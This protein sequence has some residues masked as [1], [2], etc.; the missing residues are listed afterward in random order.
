VLIEAAGSGLLES[1]HDL[2][3]GGL[4]QALVESCLSGDVGA[5]IDVPPGVDPF[6]LLFSESTGRAVV[7]VARAEETQFSELCAERGLPCQRLGEVDVLAGELEVV[8]QFRLPL[9]ELRRASSEPLS[10]RFER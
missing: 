10:T 5:R 8:G 1:A 6:V 2:S 9:R 4:A 3:E 7:S